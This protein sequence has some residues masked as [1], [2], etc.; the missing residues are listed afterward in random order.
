MAS[1]NVWYFLTP[2]PSPMGTLLRNRTFIIILAKS[3]IPPLECVVI[4]ERPLRGHILE[5]WTKTECS[6]LEA[7]M[8]MYDKTYLIFFLL[9]DLVV[10]LTDFNNIYNLQI[11]NVFFWWICMYDFCIIY[12]LKQK[13]EHY[14]FK[15]VFF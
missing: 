13:L 5:K 6:P 11:F 9:I 8:F 14:V 4:Y 2:P 12:Y 1:C 10:K 3:L 7:T 15:I